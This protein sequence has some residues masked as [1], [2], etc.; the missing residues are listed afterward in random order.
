MQEDA[1]KQL[2]SLKVDGGAC[3]NNYLMQFQ[4]DMLNCPVERPKVIETTAMGAAYLAGLKAGI[5]TKSDILEFRKIDKIFAPEMSTEKRKV[6]YS[7][8]Q[9]AVERSKDWVEH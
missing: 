3:A 8:W 6:L 1:G 9:K 2:A 5:W 7:N 4:S